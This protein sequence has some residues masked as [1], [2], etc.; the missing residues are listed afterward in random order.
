ML[1]M[2]IS[3]C[4]NSGGDFHFGVNPST[5]IIS[6]AQSAAIGSLDTAVESFNRTVPS[7]RQNLIIDKRTS[8][9]GLLSL[10][11]DDLKKQYPNDFPKS[12]TSKILRTVK[13]RLEKFCQVVYHY[14]S[15]MDILVSSHPE[16]AALA[17]KLV[18]TLDWMDS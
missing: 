12:K 9:T 17:C 6:L 1:A 16:I 10:V 15:V 11:K 2:S 18:S 7:D 5:D 3:R 8:F 14:S 4:I 13:S